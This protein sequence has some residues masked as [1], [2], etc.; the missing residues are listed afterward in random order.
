MSYA[1]IPTELWALPQ[2]VGFMLVENPERGKPDKVPVNPHTLR[3]AS[4]ARPETWASIESA[5]ATVKKSGTVMRNGAPVSGEIC[6]VGFM[7]NAGGIVGIDFDHCVENGQVSHWV[8]A[9]VQKFDSYTEYSPSGTG[10]HIICKGSLHGRKSVKTASVEIY[11]RARYFTVTGEPYGEKKPLREAQE[12]LDA[13]YAECGE[14][15][16]ATPSVGISEGGSVL[17]DSEVIDRILRSER[18]PLWSGDWSAYPSQSEADMALCNELAFYCGR[19]TEQMDRLFRQSGLV[20]DKWDKL[21]GSRT[22]GERT[23]E[24]AAS[25]CKKVYDPTYNGPTAEQDFAAYKRMDYTRISAECAAS[26]D[27]ALTPDIR[28][29]VDGILAQGVTFL[30]AFSKVGKSRMT[31]QMLLEI[32]RGRPFLG[33]KSHKCDALYLALEDERIDFEKRL[34]AFLQGEHPPRNLYY[35]TK[36]QFDYDTPALGNGLLE[37]LE[38]QLKAHPGIGVIAIDV[39]GI[40]RSKRQMNEDFAMHERRD[41]DALIRF[42]AQHDGLAILIAHHVSKAGLH[43]SRSNAT[44]SGAGSYVISGTVHAE[45]EIALDPEN[46]HRARFSVKGRRMP[47]SSFAIRDEYPFWKLVGDWDVIKLEEDPIVAT[48][49]WL[50]K[51]YGRWRG[52]ATEFY[53]INSSSRDLPPIKK[54]KLNKNDFGKR[55]QD[56]LKVGIRYTQ[57]PHGNASPIHEFKPTGDT[58]YSF[59]SDVSEQKN[60]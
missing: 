22:Y 19:D 60:A 9:W 17:T 57:R 54:A 49:K 37:F 46:E 35:V 7:F 25:D 32:S 8:N 18:A 21:A 36:E 58:D 10:I 33:R 3:G 11:D 39:F 31:L 15:S 51:E 38:A 20:R 5:A 14:T 53:E 48:A 29:Y 30:N 26:I 55:A 28:F 2:W 59:K 43:Q 56:F 27:F 24:K 44:G 16:T 13:L 45:M 42:T 4:P 47:A 41:I 50:I 12:I 40:I 34:K 52:S 1:N 23:L 6:G